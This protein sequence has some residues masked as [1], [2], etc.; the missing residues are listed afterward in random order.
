MNETMEQFTLRSIYLSDMMVRTPHILEQ[1]FDPKS[2][3]VNVKLGRNVGEVQGIGNG[4]SY[5]LSLSCIVTIQHMRTVYANIKVGYT[6]VVE[7][8][9]RVADRI[10]CEGML[11]QCAELLYNKMRNMVYHITDSL[12]IKPVMLGDTL[13]ESYINAFEKQLCKKLDDYEALNEQQEGAYDGMANN[14]DDFLEEEEDDE[15]FGDY[16]DEGENEDDEDFDDFDHDEEELDAKITYVDTSKGEVLNY[17]WILEQLMKSSLSKELLQLFAQATR[18]PKLEW[19][20][21]PQFKHFYKFFAVHLF[22]LPKDLLEVADNSFINPFINLVLGEADDVAIVKKNKMVSDVDFTWK[23]E[24]F[25]L[26]QLT[27]EDVQDMTLG[28]TMKSFMHT[29]RDL[30]DKCFNTAYE[31]LMDKKTM[32]LND[33]LIYF[34][35]DGPD[36]P[37]S[38]VE[39]ATKYYKRIKTCNEA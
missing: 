18:N 3:S 4:Y 9:E 7:S 39:L 26:S 33:Y 25:L 36:A 27:L 23:G 12:S 17:K 5:A 6:A 29:G 15:D 19:R 20:E 35:C 28:L 13:F 8:E 31:A 32:T 34:Y 21:L 22:S 30:F 11:L 37:Q 2:I 1:I 10:A 38:L 14:E 16:G 24:R